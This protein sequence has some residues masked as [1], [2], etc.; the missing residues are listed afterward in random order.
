MTFI[1]N[2]IITPLA[3]LAISAGAA[4]DPA[5]VTVVI[6]NLADEVVVRLVHPLAG[7]T[8]NFKAKILEIREPLPGEYS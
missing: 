3:A 2:R 4:A 8:I 7:K 5:G 1:R 6:E